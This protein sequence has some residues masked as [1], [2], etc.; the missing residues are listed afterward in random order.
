[1]C[2]TV[3]DVFCPKAHIPNPLKGLNP[4]D[5]IG[6]LPGVGAAKDAYDAATDPFGTVVHKIGEWLTKS[7]GSMLS[8]IITK[9]LDLKD[10]NLAGDQSPVGLLQQYTYPFVAAVAVA[11]VLIAALRMAIQRRGEEAG[12]LGKGLAILILLSGG[13]VATVAL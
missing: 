12:A 8:D 2:N 5:A 6:K 4:V 3:P 7:F 1:M 10:P 11:A 13:G 9:W